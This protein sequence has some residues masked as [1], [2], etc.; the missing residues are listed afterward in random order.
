MINFNNDKFGGIRVNMSEDGSIW[1]VAK[2][3]AKALGYEKPENAVATHCE[4]R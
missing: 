3:V 4:K 2:D 1:F